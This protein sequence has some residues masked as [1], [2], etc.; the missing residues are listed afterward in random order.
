MRNGLKSKE[1]FMLNLD[2]CLFKKLTPYGYKP[3][4]RHCQSSF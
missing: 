4:E 3:A 1:T 2:E